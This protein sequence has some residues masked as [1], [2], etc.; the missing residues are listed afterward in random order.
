[1]DKAGSDIPAGREGEGNEFDGVVSS[2]SGDEYV[3]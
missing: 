1:M 3:E 2:D